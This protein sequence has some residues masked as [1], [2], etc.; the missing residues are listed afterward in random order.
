MGNF[1]PLMPFRGKT[2]IENTIDSVLSGGVQTAVVVTGFKSEELEDFLKKR[3][4]DRI[5][6][7]KNQHFKETDMMASI[8][9]GCYALPP[10]DAFFLLPGDMPMICPSTF[11]K[12][13]KA[14]C[15]DIPSVIIPTLNGY[16]KHPPL[17]DGRLITDILSFQGNGGLRQLWR[18]REELIYTVPVDDEG[19]T[20]DLDTRQDYQICIQN[21]EISG[22]KL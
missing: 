11:E 7:V 16:R 5:I 21:Y 22:G 17:I 18:Q 4:G 20:I 12:L 9:T 1:K 15:P 2:L 3:Y 10:C 6:L 19:V 14:R 8:K 13:K